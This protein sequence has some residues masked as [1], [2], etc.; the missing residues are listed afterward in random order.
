[1]SVR[2]ELKS[3]SENDDD[4]FLDVENIIYYYCYTYGEMMHRQMTVESIKR[5]KRTC[6]RLRERDSADRSRSRITPRLHFVDGQ[7][8]QTNERRSVNRIFRRRREIFHQ[9]GFSLRS[10]PKM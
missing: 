8:C 2:S 6:C 3:P 9:V 1:M 7:I 4:D 5:Y 10:S